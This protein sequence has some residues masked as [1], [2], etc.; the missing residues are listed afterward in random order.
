MNPGV[1][2]TVVTD[3][4]SPKGSQDA[5]LVA[6]LV[7]ASEQDTGSSGVK[8][9][10]AEM[11]DRLNNVLTDQLP[12]YMVPTTYIP[13]SSVPK[14]VSGKTDRRK[15]R[16]TY[17][18]NSL[19]ELIAL[20][21]SLSLRRAPTGPIELSLAQLYASTLGLQSND[22]GA[23]DS[24]LRIGGDSI[25]VM[26][27]VEAASHEGLS[28]SV[29]DVF[30]F[31]RLND[32]AKVLKVVVDNQH[33]TVLPFSLL[34]NNLDLK[35]AIASAATQC[36]SKPDRVLDIFPCAPLQEGLLSLTTKRRSDYIMRQALE[37]CDAIDME[38]FYKSWETVIATAPILR[39]RIIDLPEHGLM[40]TILKESI[41]LSSYRIELS[42]YLER[43]HQ[44]EMGLGTRL[45][46]F[47]VV[48]DPEAGKRFFVVTIHH[49]VY[50]GIS[51]DLL[52]KQL[53]RAYNKNEI[54][55]FTPFQLFV[56]YIMDNREGASEFWR[57]YLSNSEAIPFPALPEPEYQPTT[58]G[59]VRHQ[60]SPLSWPQNDITP[61][62]TLRTALS[63]L[64]ARHTFSSQAVFGAVVSGRQA[65]VHRM[66]HV[67]GPTIATVPVRVNIDWD[68]SITQLLNQVQTGALEMIPFEQTGLHQ[69]RRINEDTKRACKFQTLLVVQ[70]IIDE[71]E[72]GKALF[73]RISQPSARAH[74]GDREPIN[75]NFNSHALVLICQLQTNAVDV[76]A[77]FDSRVIRE[78]AVES[79]VL[80]LKHI[81][82]QICQIGAAPQLRVK[83]I[84]TACNDDLG[85]IWQWNATVPVPVETCI[86][87]LIARRI[88]S[89]PNAKAIH[90]WDGD[91]TYKELD[92]LSTH[93]AHHLVWQLGLKQNMVIPLYFKKSIWMP[94]A[95]LTVMKAGGASLALDIGQ[96]EDRLRSILNQVQ[97]KVILSSSKQDLIKKIPLKDT[98]VVFVNRETLQGHINLQ[99]SQSLPLPAV[100]P[101]S[102]LYVV[103]TSGSTGVPK[104]V[105]IT[106]SN[107]SSA[108]KYQ[109]S[110]LKF[111]PTD[112]VFDFAS[113]AFDASWSNILH[114]LTSGGCLCIPSEIDRR[115]DVATCMNQ[116]QVTYADLTPSVLNLIP[117]PHM[118][119]TLQTLILAGEP[120]TSQNIQTWHG[121]VS[122]NNIYGPAE[123]TPTATAAV[124]TSKSSD[125]ANIGRG[126][127]LTTWVVTEHDTLAPVGAIGEL[128][129]EGPLVGQGYLSDPRKTANSFVNSPTWLI[130]G[131]PHH[132]GRKGR[133][134]KTGD[135]V[136]YNNTDGTLLFVGRKDNQVKIRGQRVELSEVE[137]H[138]QRH[139]STS[140]K[141][142]VAA[143]I[144]TPTGSESPLLVVFIAVGASVNNEPLPVIRENLKSLTSG[145]AEKLQ[146]V[147]PVYMVPGAFLPLDHIPTTAAGKRDRKAL[148]QVG[149]SFTMDQVLELQPLNGERRA[150]AT[151]LESQ[152][153][154]L[155]SAVLNIEPSRIGIDDSFFS[156]GGDSIS[157]MQLSAKSR[158]CGHAISVAQIFQHRS[159][160]NLSLCAPVQ[161]YLSL[162]QDVEHDAPFSLS[163]IQQ[164]FFDVEKDGKNHFNQS[165]LLRLTN[166]IK[167]VQ[168]QHALDAIVGHHSMLRC[169]FI[170]APDG[171]WTQSVKAATACELY[172]YQVYEVESL[173][174]AKHTMIQTQQSLDIKAG[175]LFALDLIRTSND[176]QFIFM[177]AHHLIIDVVSWRIILED[178]EEL[179]RTGNL[180]SFSSLPFQTWC[181]LQAQYAED[182]LLPD[183]VL[184]FDIESPSSGYWGLSPH[185][186]THGNTVDI[187]F[188]LD[189]RL[190]TA[191]LGPVN[192]AFQTKPV[193]IFHAALLLSFA[194]AFPDRSPPTIFNEGHGREPWTPE[195]DLSKT[196]GW[197]TTMW[198]AKVDVTAKLSIK[199]VLRLTKDSRRQVPKNGWAYF[200]SRYLNSR[201]KSSFQSHGLPEITFNYLGLY[202]QLERQ[203]SIFYLSKRPKG[204]S[205]FGADARRLSIMDISALVIDGSL[206]FEFTYN[207]HMKFQSAIRSWAEL[208][209]STLSDAA[210]QLVGLEPSYTLSD[211]PLLP[212]TYDSIHQLMTQSLN[213]H[214]I[215]H[216]QIEDI[217]PCSPIQQGILLSQARDA[218]YYQA[219][220]RWCA[221]SSSTV[222]VVNVVKLRQAWESVVQRHAILRTV[223][224]DSVSSEM[225]KD[226]VVLKEM[227]PDVHVT[228]CPAEDADAHLAKHWKETSPNRQNLHSLALCQI[229]AD[230]IL[231]ELSINHAIMDAISI[232]L[233]RDDLRSAYDGALPS[234]AGPLY[235]DY[236]K[237][238]QQAPGK[239]AKEYWQKYLD[240]VQT[241]LFP[242][243]TRSQYVKAQKNTAPTKMIPQLFSKLREFC[244][245]NDLTLPNV[246]H[247]AWGLVLLC[248]TGLDTVCFGYLTSGRDVLVSDVEHIVGPFI[249]MLVSRIDFIGE[250]SLI[251]IVRHHQT[252]YLGNLIYQHY[253]LT[254]ILHNANI[255]TQALFNTMVAFQ[256]G[257]SSGENRESSTLLLED[258]GGDD[259]TEYDIIL[260]IG[261]VGESLNVS[262]TYCENVLPSSEADKVVEMFMRA[263]S[264]IINHPDSQLCQ[265]D[266]LSQADLSNI[267]QWNATV[268]PP[269][270][271]C[272]H[273]LIT[274]CVCR[275]P[276]AAAIHAWDGDLTY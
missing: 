231:C 47:A 180:T 195:I 187:A 217:Y 102:I 86:H 58:D 125:P 109:R 210:Q 3:R 36:G 253:P 171:S 248:Y 154:Q 148:K 168:V 269:V 79:M 266:I 267:W 94:V 214:D 237:Y 251:D 136:R 113:Y 209:K 95:M 2:Q 192:D 151:D 130:N 76:T 264:E 229:S 131:G 134:Y 12:V 23:E 120:M 181:R 48:E 88:Y 51:I 235:S 172:R 184:P 188:S 246:F 85:R 274:E 161:Q 162:G 265:L 203:D 193:E 249:N 191:L 98:T 177:V 33:T 262:I 115:N 21:P 201:G 273:D 146:D 108:I 1:C 247:V 166:Q 263:V 116:M 127:G 179:L 6:F 14:T 61:S 137:Y 31:P 28:F 107:F 15:L 53:A 73:N 16:D 250:R 132:P 205:D 38:N 145:V 24:F 110:E 234:L 90:A 245:G 4:I 100:D 129:L 207:K 182:H 175:P 126:L 82:Q 230:M 178:M 133:L 244:R 157:A 124:I 63:V 121:K 238:L 54:L 223:F 167:P 49:A 74:Q 198:P 19:S 252:G 37:I 159:I 156:L 18:E 144:V 174:E 242:S 142:D 218:G 96:P 169:R 141:V 185:L 62:T 30:R 128:W 45:S 200:C 155:F 112:R 241:C 40:Q 194:K 59:T 258:V 138:V 25:G 243:L 60:I 221:R 272:V 111:K 52:F 190:T 50:D 259:P 57:T 261:E 103:F 228:H 29:P 189:R 10:L 216:G 65:P 240:G 256:K 224:I 165:F 213:E 147:L 123:C 197:F 77:S 119:P 152:L 160:S 176:A 69:I 232:H 199:D 80:Q 118:V 41:K 44:E 99:P 233:L 39:T 270:E 20:Q 87:D 7:I 275:Q 104:G 122:L 13:I 149:N 84:E 276:N 170:Q 55:S 158:S 150:P 204:V 32:L 101:S 255:A 89:Q 196:V 71:T 75:S 72:D 92:N 219:R 64:T 164:M 70:P 222:S 97:P 106:H 260:N 117:G 114:T 46:H 153:Q 236:I 67:A 56:K 163:P 271:G 186:N 91:L 239:A 83:D 183:S 35:A 268:P 66:S 206:R 211:F 68:C 26:R 93:L 42:A 225:Y 5:I 8:E 202:Q 17:A 135:L 227:L 43:D 34:S 81:L 220:I 226:Q 9:G 27:L 78:D 11:I 139:L 208:C 140:H 257:A 212:L 215:S 173:Q 105:V 254:D 22:I 143:E